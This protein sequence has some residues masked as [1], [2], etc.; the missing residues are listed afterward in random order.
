MPVSNS[1]ADAII[2]RS[3]LMWHHKDT[4]VVGKGILR[5]VLVDHGQFDT[6]NRLLYL[7][8]FLGFFFKASEINVNEVF[9]V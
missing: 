6:L 3:G 5:M 9:I 8:V 2:L 7:S 4:Y 1:H